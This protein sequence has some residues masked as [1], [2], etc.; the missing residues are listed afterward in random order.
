MSTNNATVAYVRISSEEQLKK[1]A[2]SIATQT[3]KCAEA[4]ERA[5][6]ELVKV[7][8][9]EGQ[10]AFKQTSNQRPQ[11]QAML[12]FLRQNKN[13]ITHVVFENLSRLARRDAEQD[14]LLEGFK[15]AGLKY[16]SVDEPNVET[17]TAAGRLHAGILGRFN[18]YYSDALSERVTYRMRAG[19]SA[20]RHLHKAML[21]YHNGKVNGVKNLVPDP[22]RANLVRKAFTLVAEGQNMVEVLRVITALGLRSRSGKKLAKTTFSQMLHNRV[23]CGW[24]KQKDIVARGAFEPLISEELFEQVQEQMKG[25][26]KRQKHAKHHEDWP[27]RRFVVCGSCKK[28]LTS[29]YV[30]NKQG[31]P[32]GYY[33]CTRGC[34]GYSIKKDLLEAQWIA[35][36]GTMEPRTELLNAI[37]RIVAAASKHR[38]ER[39]EEERR[40]LTARL[41]EQ[42]TLNQKTIEARVKGQISEEDFAVMKESIGAETKAF[43]HQ[44]KALDDEKSGMQELT[45]VY[46]YKVKNLALFWQNASLSDRVELQFSL[47]PEGLRWTPRNAFLNTLNESLFQQ[48]EEMMRDLKLDGGR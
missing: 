46:E 10:S 39:A 15:K 14:T 40:I 11:L 44:L 18:S 20:G 43:E 21:G 1:S 36:L 22:E 12:K 6:L 31:K 3:R 30:K 34:K 7:F 13:K 19:A 2:T 26:S 37:P 17:D 8:T 32:Y 25:R 38:K 35:L 28:P 4:C 5:G 24:V 48:V 27:L 41:N 16:L 23:Y 42:K 29:G 45:Q 9:D 47:W 33:F